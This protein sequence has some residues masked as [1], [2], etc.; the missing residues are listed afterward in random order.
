MTCILIA[1][2]SAMVVGAL[3]FFTAAMFAASREDRP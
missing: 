1:G 2:V 3:G